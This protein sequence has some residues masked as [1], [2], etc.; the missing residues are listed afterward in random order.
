MRVQRQQGLWLPRS[1]NPSVRTSKISV[2]LPI[3]TFFSHTCANPFRYSFFV[4]QKIVFHRKLSCNWKRTSG[5]VRIFVVQHRW[6]IDLL[7]HGDLL[8]MF[9]IFNLSH[10]VENL[11]QIVGLDI[12]TSSF[13]FPPIICN[14]SYRYQDQI[15][16][17]NRGR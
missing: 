13:D 11:N 5:R 2:P 1:K 14:N 6:I 3:E 16:I 4:R 9:F 7:N 12:F 17:D 10:Q 8:I 15:C